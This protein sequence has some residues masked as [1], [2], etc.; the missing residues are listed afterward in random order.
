MPEFMQLGPVPVDR[1]EIRLL[2]R[3]LDEV[4]ARRIERHLA[5]DANIRPGRRNDCFNL[6]QDFCATR[7]WRE[8]RVSWD[9]LA[10]LHMENSEALQEANAA[11]VF[12]GRA[13]LRLFVLR[14]K[15][16]GIDNRR[17]LLALAHIA[18]ES[19]RLFEGQPALR[20][21]ALLDGGR[22][23]QE[24]VDPGLGSSGRCVLGQT[25]RRPS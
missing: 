13:R 24:D 4:V 7:K 15:R 1:L 16:V 10:L 17:S 22:P 18:A 11:G 2:R 21:P 25:K 23:E 5:P 12:A 9:P 19:E 20:W 3:D 6:R 8:I 14:D